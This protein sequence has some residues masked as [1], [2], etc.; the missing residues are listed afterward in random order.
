[1]ARKGKRP[2]PRRRADAPGF[3]LGLQDLALLRK[4]LSALLRL[5]KD[6]P[7]PSADGVVRLGRLM[8]L[9]DA[10]IAAGQTARQ[11]SAPPNAPPK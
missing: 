9:L 8:Q 10:G 3:E 4:G 7:E 11:N 2:S 5:A 6:G 1:M